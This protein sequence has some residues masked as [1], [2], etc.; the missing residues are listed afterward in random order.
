MNATHEDKMMLSFRGLML[1]FIT[2]KTFDWKDF[3]GHRSSKDLRRPEPSWLPAAS[4][5]CPQ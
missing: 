5:T 4:C 1:H 2:N 3:E